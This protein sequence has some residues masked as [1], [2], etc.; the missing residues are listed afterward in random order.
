MTSKRMAVERT[1]IKLQLNMDHPKAVVKNH[2][3]S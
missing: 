3:N 2:T 1:G